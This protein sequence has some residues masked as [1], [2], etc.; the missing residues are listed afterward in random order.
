MEVQ[1]NYI[2]EDERFVDFMLEDGELLFVSTFLNTVPKMGKV[3]VPTTYL[4]DN[5]LDVVNKAGS[6]KKISK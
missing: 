6:A 3:Q 4:L 1:L 5:K 2:L